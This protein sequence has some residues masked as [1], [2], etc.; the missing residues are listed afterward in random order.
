MPEQHRNDVAVVIRLPRELRDRLAD[1]AIVEDRS[2]A[3]L[4]RVAAT[5][6]LAR[7]AHEAPERP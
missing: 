6:Y 7:H 2:I 1:H 3:S 5:S 4:M